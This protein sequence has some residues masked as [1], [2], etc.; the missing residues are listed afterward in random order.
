MRG[1]VA[2]RIAALVV[3]DFAPIEGATQHKFYCRGVGLVREAFPDGST[4]DLIEFELV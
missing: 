1:T 4:I 3:L 2:Q